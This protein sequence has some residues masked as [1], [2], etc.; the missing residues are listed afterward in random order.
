[1]KRNIILGLSL[2]LIT[3]TLFAAATSMGN[4]VKSDKQESVSGG[5][6]HTTAPSINGNLNLNAQYLV[7]KEDLDYNN[8]DN[9]SLKNA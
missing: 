7:Y 4:N 6:Y 1:M 2:F 5:G 3:G 9:A 8:V